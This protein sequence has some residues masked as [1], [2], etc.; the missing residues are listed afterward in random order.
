MDASRVRWVAVAIGIAVAGPAFAYNIT[1]ASK[2]TSF[3]GAGTLFD[4]EFGPSTATP[5]INCVVGSSLNCAG[6][7]TG[8]VVLSAV[9][10]PGSIFSGWSNCPNPQ[11]T[12]GVHTGSF[13]VL[14]STVADKRVFAYFKPTLYTLTV[15]PGAGGTITVG[16]NPPCAASATCTYS[17][18]AGTTAALTATPEPGRLFR[19]WA[20]CT[21][22][23]ATCSLYVDGAKVVSAAFF[24]AT[25]Y[26]VVVT[27]AGTAAAGS[28]T[29]PGISCPGDCAATVAPGG[30][31]TLTA[32][33][34]GFQEWYGCTVAAGSACELVDVASNQAITAQYATTTCGACHGKPPLPPHVARTDCGT[35]HTGYTENSV[36]RETH[37]D[38]KIDPTHAAAVGDLCT[39]DPDVTARCVTC[40]PCFGL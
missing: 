6:A 1:V 28:V 30:S 25:E 35:C 18:G 26:E 22:S 21:S 13:C 23:T 37:M 19:S 14:P 33:G 39:T 36:V 29:G 31:L 12:Y 9:P 8:V 5:R 24:T 32:A 40:H 2:A 16:A 11:T 20:G 34:A 4:A 15:K 3:G 38:G 7:A 10:A 27:V 17:L